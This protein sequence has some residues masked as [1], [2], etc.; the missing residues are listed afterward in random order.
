MLLRT[1]TRKVALTLKI[2]CISTITVTYFIIGLLSSGKTT[3]IK[4]NAIG[5]L[6]I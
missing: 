3:Y 2:I 5:K 1:E 6:K 4:E